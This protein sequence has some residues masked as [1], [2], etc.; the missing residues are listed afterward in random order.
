MELWRTLGIESNDV[1]IGLNDL[2]DSEQLSGDFAAAER[3]YLEALRIAKVIDFRE[4]VANITGNLAA[5]ALERKDW[6][7]AEALAR[8]ALPLAEKVGRKELIAVN[9]IRIAVALARQGQKPEA[10]PYAQR[11]VEIFTA[12][13]HPELEAARKTLMECES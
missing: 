5:L 3:D 8:E 2:A 4:G 7:G 10:L 9:C 12:L 11:S 13:R 6:P 1:V